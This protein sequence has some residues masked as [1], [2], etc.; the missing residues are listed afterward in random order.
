MTLP[1]QPFPVPDI[2]KR[3]EASGRIGELIGC[4]E[5]IVVEIA[6]EEERVAE[7]R[8]EL[9]EHSGRLSK[10]RE[11]LQSLNSDPFKIQPCALSGPS[12]GPRSNSEKVALFRS[13][14]RGREDIF[15][16]R[17]E[18]P[19]SGKSGYS[20]ACLNEWEYGLC[21]KKRPRPE[22]RR[23]TCGECPN[24]AFHPVDDAVVVA[25]LQGRHVMGVYPLLKD[26]TCWFLAADFDKVRRC[27]SFRIAAGSWR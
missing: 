15:P 9:E 7:L 12:T 23:V 2:L 1:E 4:R 26:E 3:P 17:W 20:P 25:H 19:K 24:Q 14:F 22:G 18:N 10:L 5:E 21:E 27:R 16:R 8:S 6:R 11:E 13:L